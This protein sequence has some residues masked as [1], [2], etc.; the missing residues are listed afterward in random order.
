MCDTGV[1]IFTCKKIKNLA[2]VNDGAKTNEQPA[3]LS[4]I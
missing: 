2:K 3:N 4:N 1:V